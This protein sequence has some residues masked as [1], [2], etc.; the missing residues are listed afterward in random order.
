MENVFGMKS[1]NCLGISV[2]PSA[3]GLK[4]IEAGLHEAACSK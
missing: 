2:P 3:K 4:A 1:P